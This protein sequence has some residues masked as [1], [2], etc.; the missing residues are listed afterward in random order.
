MKYK[1]IVF[2]GTSHI[3]KESYDQ[4]KVQVQNNKPDIITL[5]LDMKRFQALL[6]GHKRSHSL[7]SIRTI[8]L[9]GYIF[10]FIGAWAE[11]KLGELTGFSPGSEM[12]HAIK[13]AKKNKISLALIDQDI[14]I[15]L[16]KLS[17]HLSWKEKFNFVIDI[18]KALITRKR[19]FEFDLQKVPEEKIIKKLLN[20]VKTRY[21]NVYKV[22]I[23]DRNKFMF[24][25]LKKLS[26]QH[27][28]K[29]ILAIIGAGHLDG[30][31]KMLKSHSD[32][33]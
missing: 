27:P 20:K 31:S 10:Q 8:G 7:K 33:V 15:T 26:E 13:L 5:E 24:K 12:K 11:K 22:L 18:L 30:I 14:E 9:K 29:K 17:K 4:V 32:V 23:S 16:K 3:A 2:L 1:N 25:A 19:E 21:P 6:H 28:N